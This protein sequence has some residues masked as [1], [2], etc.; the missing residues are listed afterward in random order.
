MRI[1]SVNSSKNLFVA[2][3]IMAILTGFLPIAGTLLLTGF[4]Y[5]DI[6]RETPELILTRLHEARA[7]VPYLYYAGIGGAG[8]GALFLTFLMSEI[9]GKAGGGL[10]GR[11][12]KLCGAVDGLCLYAGILRWTFLF[13]SLAA[14]RAEGAYDSRTIDLVFK[15]F[16][17]YVGDTVAEHVGFT[18]MFLWM[19]FICVGML[20]TGKFAKWIPVSGLAASAVVLYGNLEFFGAPGAFAVNRAA[21]EIAAA[22]LIAFGVY[23]ILKRGKNLDA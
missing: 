23:L 1:S 18:F 19:V 20:K 12:G 9:L 13:P 3:G 5:P 4:G 16:N 21:A 10:W 17:T 22:W 7:T 8:L 11:L 15:A 14:M 2:A 6:I